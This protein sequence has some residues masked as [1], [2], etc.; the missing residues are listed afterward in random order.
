MY[1]SKRTFVRSLANEF[2]ELDQGWSWAATCKKTCGNTRAWCKSTDE[3]QREDAAASS[4]IALLR[5][6]PRLNLRPRSTSAC[7]TLACGAHAGAQ[8]TPLPS[9]CYLLRT[10]RAD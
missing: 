8:R 1:S 3:L 7:E 9:G 5:D 2:P 10:C 4:D 6:A